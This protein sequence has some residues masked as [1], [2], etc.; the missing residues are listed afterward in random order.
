MIAFARHAFSATALTLATIAAPA[1]AAEAEVLLVIKNHRFEPAELKV[2]A[3][4]RISFVAGQYI[5][6]LL[7][8][9]QRRAGPGQQIVEHRVQA[10]GG[11]RHRDPRSRSARRRVGAVRAAAHAKPCPAIRAETLHS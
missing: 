7:E 4:Q 5:N 9:G 10:I 1:L 8:D 3:G 6:I 11:R 2:P